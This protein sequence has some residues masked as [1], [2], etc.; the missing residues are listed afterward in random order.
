MSTKRQMK[1]EHSGLKVFVYYNLHK[2]IWSIKALEGK[3]KGKVIAHSE[4]VSLFDAL[5]KVSEKGRQRVIRENKKNVHAGIVGELVFAD[6]PMVNFDKV[7]YLT[8]NPY[9]YNTFIDKET[10]RP[11]ACAQWCYLGSDRK[12]VVP[13]DAW[14]YGGM[15]L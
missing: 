14:F 11:F 8:Y 7:K 15:H 2:H 10:K 6:M 13:S 1:P 9:K 4:F 3:D 12:V 5:P